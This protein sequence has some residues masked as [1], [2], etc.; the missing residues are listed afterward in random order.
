MSYSGSSAHSVSY[1]Y[2]ADGGRTAMTDATG[3]SSYQYD[4]F[5]ELT[6]TTNGAGQVTGYGYNPDGQV[7]GITYPLP[8]TAGWATSDTVSYGY[9]NADQLNSVTDFNGHQIT[10]GNTPDGLSN[11]V[12]LGSSGDTIS[13]SYDP[14]DTPSAITLKNSTSTLQSFTYTDAPAGTILNETDTP[15]SP[16]T[17]AAYTYDPLGRVTSMTPGS[18]TRLSYG[19]DASGNLTTLPTGATTGT[20]GYDKAGE[21]TSS[22]LSGTTTSYAYDADGQRLTATQ[23]STTLTSGT[24]NGAGQLTSYTSPAGSMTAAVYDGDGM[25]AS[26]TMTPNGQSATTEN[27]V[28]NGTSLL[29]DSASAYIYTS[30]TAPAEQV[31]LAT[32]TITY[33]VTDSLGSVRGTVN[34]SG[35]LTST[36]SYDA[37]GNPQTTGGLTG[38]TPFGYAGGYTDPDGLTYLINRYYDPGTGQFTSVDPDLA[39]TLA[40]YAYAGGNPV[41]D[42]DPM[43]LGCIPYPG[44]NRCA[45]HK[46]NPFKTLAERAHYCFFYLMHKLNLKNF[47]SAAILGNLIVESGNYL[48]STQKQHNC[49]PSTTNS[50]GIGIAQWTYSPDSTQNPYMDARWDHEQAFAKK[51]HASQFSYAIQVQFV[52]QELAH[53]TNYLPNASALSDLK[54]TKDLYD[55]TWNFME[56]YERP[57]NPYQTITPRADKACKYL[58]RY[59]K[60]AHCG[61]L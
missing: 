46:P 42:G 6:S 58:Q 19:F 11:S 31:S 13:T 7:T 22:T 24:W 20:T 17:P 50:C 43:G 39:D 2:D 14:T 12:T 47:Q 4:S 45:H 55:A 34:S 33:L 21:L 40:P 8:S 26:G 56:D 15:S 5:G 61:Q 3:S 60:H 27:Y 41:S 57:G 59:Y 51:H 16:Q 1:S 52:A 18:G 37:W 9:D 25:R 32:G 29:M 53:E 35:A 49:T 10:V 38:T 30:G 54:G 48:V 44:T 23:G 36:T 28:W